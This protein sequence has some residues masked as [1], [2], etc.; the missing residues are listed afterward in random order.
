M[1]VD[2][3]FKMHRA[4]L[5]LILQGLPTNLIL[6]SIGTEIK[7]ILLG[8]QIKNSKNNI[9]VSFSLSPTSPTS[10]KIISF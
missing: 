2:A 10:P 9:G 8:Q 4:G 5:S 1:A 7:K 6:T 3:K